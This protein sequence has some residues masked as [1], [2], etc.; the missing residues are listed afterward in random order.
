ML[1]A[2]AVRGSPAGIENVDAPLTSVEVGAVNAPLA[3]VVEAVD[4]T[5]AVV[6]T[7]PDDD[8]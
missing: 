1:G 2:E 6:E 8:G 7:E 3:D 5:D 4:G